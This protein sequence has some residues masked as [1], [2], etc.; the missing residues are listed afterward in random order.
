MRMEC[1]LS[2]SLVSRYQWF[3]EGIAKVIKGPFVQIC[4]SFMTL[5]SFHVQ[6]VTTGLVPEGR[7][8][9][10]AHMQLCVFAK[11]YQ[12]VGFVS[13]SRRVVSESLQR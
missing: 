9:V 11:S 10:L 1:Y 13:V 5:A 12:S 6:C 2:H 4:V 3:P 7:I 8:V